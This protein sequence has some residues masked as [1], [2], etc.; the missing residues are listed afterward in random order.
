MHKDD[1]KYLEAYEKMLDAWMTFLSDGV[2]L[3]V[4]GTLKQNAVDIFNSFLKCHLS[5]P[6][7]TRNQVCTLCCVE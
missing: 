5:P 1:T 4:E 2:D 6:D 3:L 7:G